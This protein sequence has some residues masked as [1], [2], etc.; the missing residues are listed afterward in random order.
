M[1]PTRTPYL[2]ALLL[3]AAVAT[4]T[5]YMTPEELARPFA[6]PAPAVSPSADAGPAYDADRVFEA[7]AAFIATFQVTDPEDP[8]YGGI[9]EGED[10]L[11]IIQSDNTQESIWVWSRWRELTASR[12]Y[13]DYVARSWHY[14]DNFPAWEEEGWETPAGQ[15]YRIYNCGWGMRADIM[16]RRATG[17]N[18][19]AAYGRT[20]AEFV[21][22]NPVNLSYL[23]NYFCTAWAIGNLYA[24]AEDVNDDELKAAALTLAANVKA[25]AEGNPTGRIGNYAWAMSGGAVVW[26]L[27]NSYFREYPDEEKAWMETY[28]AY[29][30]DMIGSSASWDNAWNGWFMLGHYTAYHATG[31]AD[32]WDKFDALAANLAAQ[33]GDGDGGIPPS[34]RYTDNIHDHSWVTSYLCFMGMDRI[35]R[36]LSIADFAARAVPGAVELTW[37]RG[38]DYSADHYNVYREETG[39]IERPRVNADPITGPPPYSIQDEHIIPGRNYRYYVE[40]VSP[41]GH[42]R[43]SDPESITAGTNPLSLALAQNYPNPCHNATTVEFSLPAA[44]KATFRVTD[45]AGRQIFEE[46]QDYSA[47]KHTLPLSLRLPPGVYIYAIEQNDEMTARKFVVDR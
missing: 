3:A 10:L 13:D 23:E 35:I 7:A 21:A 1:R 25:V 31:D 17:D 19:H 18:S 27:H 45:L 15:Y 32:Y 22:E 4:A 8:N 26:G 6:P 30:P 36:D 14:V 46:T 40:A 11:N 28:G 12:E 44:G 29:M 2:A 5:Q 20:C 9:R 39:G 24:Y 41:S 33:D 34:Q 47:G 37:N 43:L 42:A 38:D 16:Y